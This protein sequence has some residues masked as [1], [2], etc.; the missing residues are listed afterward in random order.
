MHRVIEPVT[1]GTGGTFLSHVP[2]EGILIPPDHLIQCAC[3]HLRL[4]L[5]T[6]KPYTL[7]DVVPI[8]STGQRTIGIHLAG[9]LGLIQH[10][11][12]QRAGLSGEILDLIVD[13]LHL[14]L[15]KKDQS[16]F[17]PQPFGARD[18]GQFREPPATFITPLF[19]GP[20]RI[21][22]ADIFNDP[23]NSVFNLIQ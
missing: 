2:F 15:R 10:G 1:E 5:L 3:I 7:L 11:A 21:L 8:G 6:V 17:K 20:I 16:R 23:F 19:T 12:D 22:V 14:L 13:G 4:D 18:Q 9:P